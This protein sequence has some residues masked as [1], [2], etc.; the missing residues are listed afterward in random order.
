MKIVILDGATITQND[1]SW[2]ELE[3]IG[4]L[5]IH[6]RCEP[7]KVAQFIGDADAV[8]TSKCKMTAEVMDSCPNLKFIGALA[9]GYDNIDIKAARERK[10]AVCNV[11]AYST[12]SVAQHTFALL[13]EITNQVALNNDAVQ[14][15]EW[16]SSKDFCLSKNSIVQLS[17]K[18]I[19]I[20][21]YGN[22][23]K[24]VGAIAEAFGMNV[25]VYSCDKQA[26]ITS[27]V[28]TL[29]CPATAENR[30]FV[31]REFISQMKDGAILINTARGAL[32]NESDLAEALCSG[33]L[34]AAAVDVLDGEPPRNDNALIGVPNLFV[35]PHVA[36]ASLEAR[37][38]IC[39]VSVDNLK[40]FI[41]GGLLNRIC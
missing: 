7:S 22:I 9:T 13:L 11:P 20:V 23:G 34:A 21:G 18:S 29:H 3:K 31:N 5:E 38:T 17:G 27:D 14:T 30:G 15:G 39:S 2:G 26:A 1:L 33:K 41:E 6:E 32:I 4:S 28:V 16:A 40:S 36:W 35:T 10:I 12:E 37:S 8:F 19:G 25:N 24:K